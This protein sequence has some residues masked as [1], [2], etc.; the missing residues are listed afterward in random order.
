[1]IYQMMLPTHYNN[2]EK[3]PDTLLRELLLEVA[4][5]HGG[6]TLDAPS[7]GFYIDP[8]TGKHYAESVRRLTVISNDDFKLDARFLGEELKQKV[9]LLIEDGHTEFINCGL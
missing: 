1:M 5:V 3:I 7:E 9:V 8:E 6:Y 2:G 4:R